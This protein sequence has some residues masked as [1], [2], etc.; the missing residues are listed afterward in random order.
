MLGR[1]GVWTTK[2]NSTVTTVVDSLL[3]GKYVRSKRF[4]SI[5]SGTSGTAA[6]PSASTVVL[7]DFGGTVDA[8]VLQIVGGKPTQLPALTAGGVVVTSSFD[9]S[10]NYVLSGTPSAYPVALVYKVQQTWADYDSS[11][12]DIWEAPEFHDTLQP[13]NGGTGFSAYTIGDITYASA[14]NVLSKL[15]ANATATK[16]F[17]SMTSSVPSWA[18]PAFT[19]ITGAATAAQLPNP[20]V[21]ALGGVQAIVAVASNWIRSISTSGVPTLSQPAF[22]D[23]SGVAA[24]TQLPN[25]GAATLGGIKSLTATASQWIRSIGTDGLATKSQPAF[26][27]IS[28]VAVAAQIPLLLPTSGNLAAMT[29]LTGT[30]GQI[31]WNTTYKAMFHWVVDR[32]RPFGQIDPRYGF[33]V[34]DEFIGFNSAS[35][36]GWSTLTAANAGNIGTHQGL[37]YIEPTTAATRAFISAYTADMAFGVD[38]LY[39]ETMI[40]IPT[41]ATGAQD[42]CASFGFSDNSGY[43]ANA[44]CTDGAYFTLNR[45]VNAAKWITN[46]AS[47]GTTTTTNTTSANVVA[48]NWYRLTVVVLQ[49]TGNVLFYVNGVLLATHTTNIPSGAARSTGIVWK[50]DKTVGNN[51]ADMYVDYFELYGFFNGA[52][53]S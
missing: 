34:H 50:M 23:I 40:Q 18:Q 3:R 48:G 45:A 29:A 16:K 52:R 7:D 33:H 51:A 8:V 42:F 13:S 43:D 26:S 6:L 25:P 46:T 39:L 5:G 31:F 47:N 38:D 21:G 24:D 2:L 35:Q 9:A 49:S 27:D 14:T 32:W 53:V 30:D 12:A 19:D 17:F 22:S 11:S 36:M 28:G 4:I 20:A 15:A 10:G 1:G 44:A 41:L 37:W